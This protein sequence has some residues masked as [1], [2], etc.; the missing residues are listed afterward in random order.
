MTRADIA[1]RR[2]RNERLVGPPF[3][4]PEA[5]VQWLGAVQSQD[6]AGAKW[7]V[8]QRT[9]NAT[10]AGLDELFNAGKI[11]RTHVLRPTW[12]FVM[13]ADI[14]WMLA[15]TRPRVNAANAYYYRQNALDDRVFR[16]SAAALTRAMEGGR[17]LTRPEIVRVYKR[18][19]IDACGLRLALLVM[20]AELD[21][22][23]CS[24][25]LR[26]K[27][28]TYALLDERVPRASALEPDEALAELT[29]RYFTG[30]GPAQVQD[31]SWWSGLTVSQAKA[32][33]AA[34]GRGLLSEVVE[35]KTYFFAD[36]P[37]APRLKTRLV[38]LLPNYDEYFIAFKDRSATFDPTLLEGQPN[39][40]AL[41]AHIV[42]L[43]GRIVGG[44][45]R[46]VTRHEIAITTRLLV[47]LDKTEQAA[48]Q[49]AAKRY[50]RFMKR[51]VRIMASAAAPAASTG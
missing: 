42:V 43:D 48:L 36:G 7:A 11:L 41:A 14:R 37:S 5:V 20:R 24:G 12:H 9:K 39:N 6:Y 50:G 34:L 51:P 4:N 45:R 32:G 23:I 3:S 19:G 13:P 16:R 35:G 8:G 18:A 31:F 46:T 33:V 30:H 38:H 40:D 28:F 2:L 44:W 22:V 26:G 17:A 29:R 27:Q 47:R 10:D 15:L 1:R 21:A 25:P 49:E